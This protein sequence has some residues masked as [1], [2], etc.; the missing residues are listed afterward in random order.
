MQLLKHETWF[1]IV[2]TEIKT[3]LQCCS[4]LM[5]CLKRYACKRD[6]R[7]NTKPNLTV[8]PG[9]VCASNRQ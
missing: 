6:E 2:V 9:Y 3:S 7:V 4:E 5:F 1:K 8:S